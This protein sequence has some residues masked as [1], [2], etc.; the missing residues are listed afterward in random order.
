MLP[1]S[2]VVHPVT[3][4]QRVI[5][6]GK[7]TAL[8]DNNTKRWKQS[9]RVSLLLEMFTSISLLTGSIGN[10]NPAFLTGWL[11]SIAGTREIAQ[12]EG[13]GARSLHLQHGAHQQMLLSPGGA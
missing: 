4:A 11:P 6:Q 7:I 10:C 13:T 12:G 2:L 1:V 3:G 5:T 8:I 9:R